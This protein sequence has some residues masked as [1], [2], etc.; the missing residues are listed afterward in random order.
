MKGKGPTPQ[1]REAG[2]SRRSAPPLGGARLEGQVKSLVDGFVQELS[3]LVRRAALEAVRDAL[4][5]RA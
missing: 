3:A 2:G 5:D 1:K 4:G